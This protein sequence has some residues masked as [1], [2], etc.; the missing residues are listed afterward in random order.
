MN[1]RLLTG[2]GVLGLTALTGPA[3]AQGT[4]QIESPVI[5][6]VRIR[7]TVSAPATVAVPGVSG[8]PSREATRA[9]IIAKRDWEKKIRK[10]KGK[11]LGSKRYQPTR[12]R[13]MAELSEITDKTAVEPLIDVLRKEDEDVRTWL[14]EHFADRYDPAI[15]Q[16]TLA[17]LAIH[18]QE[19]TLRKSALAHLKG[20][21]QESTR[22]VVFS[23]LHS[24]N[25]QVVA[26]GAHAAGA[27]H[28][29][30]AIPQLIAAQAPSSPSMSGTGDLAYI[31]VGEQRYFVSDLQPVVGTASVGFDP[32]LTPITTGTVIRINDAVVEFYNTDA[33][34]ALLDLVRN[35]F[36]SPVDFGYDNGA[37]VK[38][39]NEEYVPFVRA[40]RLESPGMSPDH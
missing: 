36:G 27:L 31:L 30:E 40:R 4:G 23:A 34:G 33:H 18:D 3:L 17:W 38:W 28:M 32:T 2:I 1:R 39:Y 26:G 21:T 22:R 19:K 37:W 29:A 15:G 9:Y 7:T 10:I 13:G 11:Y 12:Q 24:R 16:A 5:D 20:A 25:Q 14:M 8:L 35:D 6:I